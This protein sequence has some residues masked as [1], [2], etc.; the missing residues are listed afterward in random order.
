VIITCELDIAA[1]L[2]FVFELVDDDDKLKEWMDGV[3]AISYPEGQNRSDPIGTPF[4]MRIREGGRAKD[5]DGRVVA[6][7]KPHHL[8][9]TIGDSMFEMLVNYRFERGPGGTRLNY[10]CEMTRGNRFVR[11]MGWLF[12]PLTKRIVRKQMTALKSLAEREASQ[13]DVP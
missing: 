7:E 5:Y 11:V 6:Y 3:E 4:R 13:I 12:R 8:A 9:I 2:E 10:A 1:P